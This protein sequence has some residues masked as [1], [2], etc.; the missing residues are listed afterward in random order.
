VLDQHPGDDFVI[1]LPAARVTELIATGTGR[2]CDPR[3]WRPMKKWVRVKPTDEET[4]SAYLME[5]H[6]FVADLANR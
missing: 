6:D 3:R 5:A 1:K 2:A 4:C